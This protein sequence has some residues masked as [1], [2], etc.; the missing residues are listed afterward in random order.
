[1]VT[2]SKRYGGEI[3]WQRGFV[4]VV[5]QAEGWRAGGERMM[6]SR[7]ARTADEKWKKNGHQCRATGMLVSSRAARGAEKKMQWLDILA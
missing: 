3:L 6:T 7:Q 5:K 2:L 1:V 4:M